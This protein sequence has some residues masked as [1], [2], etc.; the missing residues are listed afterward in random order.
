V[1]DVALVKGVPA[2]DVDLIT[3]AEEGH[4]QDADGV[5]ER[6]R[7]VDGER[8]DGEAFGVALFPSLDLAEIQIE[9]ERGG[10]FE[11]GVC[12]IHRHASTHCGGRFAKNASMPSLPSALETT[13]SR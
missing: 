1:T 12:F 7:D 3:A 11:D 5:E 2:D 6:S 8:S 4:G 13:R 9:D 10:A